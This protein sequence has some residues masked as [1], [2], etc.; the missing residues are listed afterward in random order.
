MTLVECFDNNPINNIVGC[1]RFRPERVIFIGTENNIKKP[2]KIFQKILDERG[3][4]TEIIIQNVNLNNPTEITQ[5]LSDIVKNE[6]F[7]TIDVNGGNARVLMAVG[8]LWNSLSES[9]QKRVTIQG[10]NQFTE[11]DIDLDGD[12]RL[13]NGERISLTA[14]ELIAL[15][16][17]IIYPRIDQQYD[18][19]TVDSLK[20]F[21]K[22]MAHPTIDW[23]KA[24]SYL[25]EFESCSISDTEIYVNLE[26]VSDQIYNFDNKLNTL[27]NLLLM[28]E[29]NAII[30]NRSFGSILRYDYLDTF[31]HYCT[32]KAGNVLELKTLFEARIAKTDDGENLFDDY[33][34]GVNI[35][36]DGIIHNSAEHLKE[37][38]NEIDVLTIRGVTPLFISCKNGEFDDNELYKLNT[39]AQR[40]GGKKARKA[41]V[42]N[43]NEITD[44]LRRRAKDMSIYLIENAAGLTHEEWK[45][46]FEEAMKM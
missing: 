3:I 28:L 13:I 12:G 24:I 34:M 8:A 21:F 5:V 27:Y 32:R 14:S 42:A 37:T 7:C 17:G 29:N 35:D 19:Y 18:A 38:R 9:Q 23:N 11:K 25:N 43:G 10:Y 6:F 40:F 36:W 15:H 20:P 26:S 16:G 45:K 33:C 22:I 2:A 1:L 46:E 39:V 4:F 41:L 30:R 31:G 44:S